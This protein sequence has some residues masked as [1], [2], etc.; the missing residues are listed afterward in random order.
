MPGKAEE[1]QALLNDWWVA[2]NL[3]W[4]WGGWEAVAGSK[5]GPES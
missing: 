3:S 1:K 5:A 4:S 2:E